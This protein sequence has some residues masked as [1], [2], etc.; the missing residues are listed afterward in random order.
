MVC[1]IVGIMST[2][3]RIRIGA[4]EYYGTLLSFNN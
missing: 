4:L 3:I 2:G 1:I